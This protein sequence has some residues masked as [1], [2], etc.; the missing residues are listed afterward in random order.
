MNNDLLIQSK[1]EIEVKALVEDNKP[2]EVNIEA[3]VVEPE[4]DLKPQISDEQP[5]APAKATRKPKFDF[6]N[7]KESVIF[8][9]E[10]GKKKPSV[11]SAVRSKSKET[12][13]ATDTLNG[14]KFGSIDST[15]T[16]DEEEEEETTPRN[17]DIDQ[18]SESVN[19]AQLSVIK[20]KTPPKL[21]KK[22]KNLLKTN[23][24][25]SSSKSSSSMSI[26]TS[27]NRTA[28]SSTTTSSTDNEEA[29]ADANKL[30][31]ASNRKAKL[32]SNSNI[33]NQSKASSSKQRLKSNSNATIT[34]STASI[35]TA[36]Q[37]HKVD[38]SLSHDSSIIKNGPLI[39]GLNSS[40]VHTFPAINL[41]QHLPHYPPQG[42]PQGPPYFFYNPNPQINNPYMTAYYAPVNNVNGPGG[43]NSNNGPYNY[44]MP[45][46]FPPG[47]IAA[48]NFY[49]VPPPPIMSNQQPIIYQNPNSLSHGKQTTIQSS[50]SNQNL[51]IS[52]ND[53]ETINKQIQSSASS[54]TSPLLQNPPILTEQHETAANTTTTNQSSQSAESSNSTTPTPKAQT[55]Q[56]KIT[57]YQNIQH[58]QHIQINPQHHPQGMPIIQIPPDYYHQQHNFIPSGIPPNA[59]IHPGQFPYPYMPPPHIEYIQNDG[60]IPV[61]LNN[62]PVH[63]VNSLAIKTLNSSSVSSGNMSPSNHEIG[64]LEKF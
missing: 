57:E 64:K 63:I 31:S 30:R 10:I 43:N 13:L 23:S 42:P 21:L 18:I 59:F 8:C 24:N 53:V 56:S 26:K 25:S 41:P 29:N 28:T 2:S 19:Q 44:P 22:N 17:L 51:T 38:E 20:T 12:L 48:H 39:S 33:R 45:N 4:E 14:I 60:L 32:K 6:M 3:A 11:T 46:Q 9:D 40:Q 37:V 5:V 36:S 1:P 49:A 55:S 34:A 52:N 47:V 58:I 16:S 27:T 35:T 61:P 62:M 50:P 7:N 15:S 54:S